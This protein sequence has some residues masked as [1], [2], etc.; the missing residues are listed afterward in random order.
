ML[1]CIV[2]LK[3][4]E[5]VHFGVVSVVPKE[6]IITA[7]DRIHEYDLMTL[8]KAEV[9]FN[10]KFELRSSQVCKV[11]VHTLVLWFD[12]DFSSRFCCEKPVCLTT[13]PLT[14]PTH[15]GQTILHLKEAISIAPH[16]DSECSQDTTIIKGVLSVSRSSAHRSIDIC[17]RVRGYDSFGHTTTEEQYLIYEI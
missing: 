11:D 14:K 16:I 5:C 8:K 13:S 17:V 9:P 15:W 10:S 6:E 3:I 12:V 1:A 2:W 7:V 4:Q